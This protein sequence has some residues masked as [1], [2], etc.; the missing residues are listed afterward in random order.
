MIRE[1]FELG[2]RV[3]LREDPNPYTSM[4]NGVVVRYLGQHNYQSPR[5]RWASGWGITSHAEDLRRQT[6]E[7]RVQPLPF[8]TD[9][10]MNNYERAVAMYEQGGQYAVYRAVEAGVLHAE[11]WSWCIPCEDNTPYEDD[12]CLVCGSAKETP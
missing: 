12:C 2:D 11:G 1:R 8:T 10:D 3:E 6:R 9:G 7:E 5:V 4:R